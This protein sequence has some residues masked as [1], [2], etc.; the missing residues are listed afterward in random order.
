M[1]KAF[2]GPVATA[3]VRAGEVKCCPCGAYSLWKCM[4]PGWW[5]DPGEVREANLQ[6]QSPQAGKRAGIGA[7]GEGVAFRRIRLSALILIGW[8]ADSEMLQI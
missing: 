6:E 2:L 4:F 5:G 1:S 7:P 3:A 8:K